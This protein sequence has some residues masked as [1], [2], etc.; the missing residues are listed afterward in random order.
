MT[1]Y[2]DHPEEK[3]LFKRRIEGLRGIK[4]EREGYRS[5]R[6][7]VEEP[8]LLEELKRSSK[9]KERLTLEDIHFYVSPLLKHPAIKL[10]FSIMTF[11]FAVGITSFALCSMFV[12]P[13]LKTT[14]GR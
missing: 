4:I 6:L 2:F 8:R 3:I 5:L 7:V 1:L 9:G 11:G 12:I 14:F 13:S 10:A